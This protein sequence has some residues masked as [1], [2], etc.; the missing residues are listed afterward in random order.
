M[1][2]NSLSTQKQP[3]PVIIPSFPTSGPLPHQ[4]CPWKSGVTYGSSLYSPRKI[5]GAASDPLTKPS[6]GKVREAD[7][8]AFM[9][10]AKGAVGTERLKVKRDRTRES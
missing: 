10:A 2:R 9:A 8:C 5:T 4:R 1:R 6:S 7:H 3:S